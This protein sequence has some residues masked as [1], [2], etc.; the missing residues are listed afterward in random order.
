[1]QIYELYQLIAIGTSISCAIGLAVALCVRI[2]V[3]SVM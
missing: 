3:V 1:M 2:V